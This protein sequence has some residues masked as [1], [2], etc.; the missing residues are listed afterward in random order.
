MFKR[1]SFRLLQNAVKTQANAQRLFEMAKALQSK[2]TEQRKLAYTEADKE[3]LAELKLQAAALKAD[4]TQAGNA[5]AEVISERNMLEA[6]LA[7]CKVKV[8]D[9]NKALSV[10]EADF[11]LAQAAVEAVQAEL[12]E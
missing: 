5:H 12:S 1:G 10:A 8:E 3:R 6:T 9:T 11:N 2:A 4:Y 7:S